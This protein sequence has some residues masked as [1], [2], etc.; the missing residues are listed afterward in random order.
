MKLEQIKKIPPTYINSGIPQKFYDA[1]LKDF[2]ILGNK[3]EKEFN[4]NSF[5]EF[6]DYYNNLEENILNGYGL[7]LCGSK[8]IGK[9][10]LMTI[11]AK[12][13]IE[14]YMS[15]NRDIQAHY[16]VQSEYEDKINKLCFIQATSLI[17]LT[18]R[19]TCSPKELE[20]A[21][22][23]KSFSGVCVDDLTKIQTFKDQKEFSILDD[24][25]R[26]RDLNQLPTW[27]TSQM[28]VESLTKILPSPL[29]DIL[30]SNFKEIVFVGDSQRGL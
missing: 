9:S 18:F 19:S 28:D 25:F 17:Q 6:K 14:I 24:L 10:M 22:N 5:E 26:F 8:G 1:K 3:Q 15:W 23:L 30:K 27:V 12:K 4:S 20:L 21:Y 11:L 2:K 29:M 16:K 13:A 7:I